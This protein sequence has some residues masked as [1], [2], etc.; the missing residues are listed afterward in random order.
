MASRPCMEQG[1]RFLTSTPAETKYEQEAKEVC[2]DKIASGDLLWHTPGRL[3]NKI[4]HPNNFAGVAKSQ[5]DNGVVTYTRFLL[6][7][8][9]PPGKPD[10]QKIPA[11]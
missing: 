11:Y 9:N 6:E 5:D 3:T 10:D 8:P 4:Q 7:Q 2:E 1:G